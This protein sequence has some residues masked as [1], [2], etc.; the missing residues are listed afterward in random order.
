MTAAIL[1]GMNDTT[2]E[3]SS[4]TARSWLLAI[5][6]GGLGFLLILLANN[7]AEQSVNTTAALWLGILLE[8]LGIAAAIL[9]E[10]VHT[11]IN[12][13]TRS[14]HITRKS[15][16][17]QHT[18][19]ISFAD[20]QSVRVVM[21][22]RQSGTTKASRYL[23]LSYWIAID[24]KSGASIATGRWS[25]N[26][27]EIDQLAKKM[28]LNIGCEAHPGPRRFPLGGYHGAVAALGAI[29]LYILFYRFWAGPWCIAMWFGTL[30]PIF[31]GMSFFAI[32]AP[33]RRF[34][35]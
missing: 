30:P 24:L 5:S 26:Q 29:L 1:Y 27:N 28:S 11:I 20:V 23:R 4:N 31:M 25:R 15:W 3:I 7:Q 2:L 13:T 32:L 33:L 34:W 17:G 12:P 6:A 10:D 8:G 14:I 19:S 35:R 21:I 16:W 9:M 18:S 22:G